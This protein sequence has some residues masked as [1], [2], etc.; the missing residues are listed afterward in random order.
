MPGDGAAFKKVIDTRKTT[1]RTE[2][3]KAPAG[4]VDNVE[5]L[6]QKYR[7]SPADVR[8]GIQ[9][10]IMAAAGTAA[11][12]SMIPFESNFGSVL[13]GR[14]L[15]DLLSP[16]MSVAVNGPTRD[17]LENIFPTSEL[18]V[19]M[20]VTG[21][22]GGALTAIDLIDTAVDAGIKDKEIKKLLKIAMHKAYDKETSDDFALVKRYRDTLI[23]AEIEYGRAVI[24]QEITERYSA[25]KEL[26]KQQKAEA[27]AAAAAGLAP[28]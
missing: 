9:A 17:Y 2:A 3:S 22:E 5:D 12:L 20:L 25:L 28:A 27:P 21:I 16:G 11:A 19:R 1:D 6:I 8:A 10:G 4:I 14:L 23:T 18:N 15:G 7:G 24:D 13:A 26:I